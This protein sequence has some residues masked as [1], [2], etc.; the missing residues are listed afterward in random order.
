MPSHQIRVGEELYRTART[1]RRALGF[2]PDAPLN[3]VMDELLRDGIE[4]RRLQNLRQERASL[5]ALWA[6]E[7]DDLHESV[8]QTMHWIAE[9]GGV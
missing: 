5:Y 9:A 1:Q 4:F 3:K 2:A 6:G 7:D 8:V